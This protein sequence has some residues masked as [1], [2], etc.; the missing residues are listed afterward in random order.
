[1]GCQ[2]LCGATGEILSREGIHSEVFDPK[3]PA[4]AHDLTH[5]LLA[6]VVAIVLRHATCQGKAA[7]SVHN[8][9][10]MGGDRSFLHPFDEHAVVQQP[11]AALEPAYLH[12]LVW[13]AISPLCPCGWL[14]V[15]VSMPLYHGGLSSLSIVCCATATLGFIIQC[16]SPIRR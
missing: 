12:V 15:R 9:G 11:E 1:K 7:V 10:H 5:F 4:P 14:C 8:N 16:I 2:F 13:V 6:E 3:V